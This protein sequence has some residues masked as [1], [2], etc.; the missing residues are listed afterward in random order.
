MERNKGFNCRG[1]SNGVV[2]Q[3]GSGKVKDFLA[4]VF[5]FLDVDC[6]GS[7]EDNL[8]FLRNFLP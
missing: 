7:Q 3:L 4:R 5:V 6:L 2:I 8:E 1:T